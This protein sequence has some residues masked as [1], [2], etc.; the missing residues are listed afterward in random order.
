MSENPK[1]IRDLSR[2]P[3]TYVHVVGLSYAA[4][5]LEKVIATATGSKEI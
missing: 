2:K 5:S 3:N 4:S 1:G